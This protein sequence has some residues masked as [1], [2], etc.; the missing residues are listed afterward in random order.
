MIYVYDPTGKLV[1]WNDDEF[2]PTDSTI[3]DLTLQMS[4]KYTVEVDS[5]NNNTDRR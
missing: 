5:Y 3:V 4:G 2:E 1:A